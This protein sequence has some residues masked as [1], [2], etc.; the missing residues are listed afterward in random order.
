MSYTNIKI[1]KK[2]VDVW[3]ITDNTTPIG[4]NGH[5]SNQWA[6]IVNGNYLTIK[7]DTGQ[8]IYNKEPYNVFQ[9]VDELDSGNNLNA[10]ASSL[11]LAI[12]L[13]QQGFFPD[14]ANGGGGVD[15]FLELQD[16]LIPNYFGRDGQYVKVSGNG[17]STG[18]PSFDAQNN[19]AIWLNFQN[20]VEGTGY[21]TSQNVADY[22]NAQPY[23]WIFSEISTPIIFEFQRE[24][25]GKNMRFLFLFTRGKGEWGA[26]NGTRPEE[27]WF[28]ATNIK[29]LSV[30]PLTLE[31]VSSDPN[32]QIHDLG[33]IND[34]D[35]ITTANET[36]TWNF[37]D[38]GQ[39]EPGEQIT[40]YF[41]Y[42]ENGIT[43]LVRFIGTPGYYGVDETPFVEADFSPVTD[44]DVQPDITNTSQLINDGEDGTSPYSTQN[45]VNGLTI[46]ANQPTAEI[47]LKN[48]DGTILATLNVG[49]LNNEGT[50]FYYN[51]ATQELELKDDQGNVLSSIPVSAFV[52]NLIQ[53]VNFNG[54]TPYVLEFKD[55]E[56]NVVDSVSFSISNIQGLQTALDGKMST[57]H[58]ANAI[59]NP[60][61]IR[62][63]KKFSAD[64]NNPIV[65]ESYGTSGESLNNLP[66]GSYS[67]TLSTGAT[68]KPFFNVGG[69]ISFGSTTHGTQII[70]ARI[71]N[72]IWF[73]PI[74]LTFGSWYRLWNSGDFSSADVS[75]WNQ[76]FIDVQ[77]LQ[78]EV[79]LKADLVDGKVPSSQLPSFVDDVLE[80]ANLAAF[81]ATG[82]SGKLYVAIDTNLVYRW[83]GSVYAV[84]SSSLALGETST[85]AYRGDR[86]KTAY[87]HS[88]ATGNP[89]DTQISDIS[90]LAGDLA[91]KAPLA[92]P[93]FTGNPSAPTQPVGDDSIRL[94]NTEYVRTAIDKF[95]VSTETNLNNYI[96]NGNFRTPTS[97]LTNLPSGWMQKGYVLYVHG[98]E[99]TAYGAHILVDPSSG[100]F[101]VRGKSS[102][103]T[104]SAW[105]KISDKADLISPV[106]AGTPTAPTPATGTNNQQVATAEF[107]HLQSVKNIVTS[108]VSGSYGN[109][110]LPA[111]H[112]NISF[113]G[114][115]DGT[116]NIP[117][118]GIAGRT[119]NVYNISDFNLTVNIE[120]GTNNI[121]RLGTLINTMD[122][123]AGGGS[124]TL[125][126]NGSVWIYKQ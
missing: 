70:G 95:V 20:E 57:S 85:T 61:I 52:S 22:L 106:F 32:A 44:S 82:E 104:W 126:D 59:T 68:D 60:D 69:L 30:T 37:T 117:I 8:I 58:P 79:D 27:Y 6:G 94:A 99:L 93:V 120:S 96:T 101:A 18:S 56:G 67:V 123:G 110:D 49:F 75:N 23:S 21:I 55:A 50:T 125:Y 88:Q 15:T 63:N 71:G 42:I 105:K 121:Y 31:D 72:D 35:Y 34:G 87:D 2:A 62:W 26:L 24:I 102:G 14:S 38:S 17:L 64:F 1:T 115:V 66:L 86:G 28:Y 122:A 16:V 46:E 45:W 108:E 7:T 19:T 33:V 103:G 47:Y 10:P 65:S 98:N 91:S 116:I 3:E 92:S 77:S 29:P 84:T 73:R 111:F 11:Q 74:N 109:S 54:A 89:H 9:Y 83:T 107:V 97:G 25:Q 124:F 53:S 76:A 112:N 81:P 100:E 90:G 4:G 113:N 41:S 43:K 119:L 78:G 5:F 40:H 118:A 13:T 80:Y 48:V 36:A 51:E 39:G 114:A 12:H